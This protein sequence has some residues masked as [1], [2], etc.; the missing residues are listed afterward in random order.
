MPEDFQKELEKL[1]NVDEYAPEMLKRVAPIME[2]AVIKQLSK[3]HRTGGL[4]GSI[5]ASKPKRFKNGGW[6]VSIAPNGKDKYGTAY[7]AI[8]V[9][10]EN[11][12]RLRSDKSKYRQPPQPFFSA[13]VKDA[14]P[15]I[16]QALYEEL[17]AAM[18]KGG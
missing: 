2:K 3:H 5:K 12:T 17:E 1:S 10:L 4:E 7:A 18:K 6:Y 16:E 14:E 11:G 13:A 15:S 8:A 9:Y